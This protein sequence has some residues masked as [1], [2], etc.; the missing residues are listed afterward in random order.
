[1]NSLMKLTI[2]LKNIVFFK[3]FIQKLKHHS[4]FLTAVHHTKKEVKS[5]LLVVLTSDLTKT[6]RSYQNKKTTSSTTTYLLGST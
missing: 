5:T 2:S 1:M 6:I 3:I 4:I